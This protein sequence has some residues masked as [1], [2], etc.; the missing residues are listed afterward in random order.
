M[1][2]SF[3]LGHWILKLNGVIDESLMIEAINQA[4]EAEMFKQISFTGSESFLYPDLLIKGSSY[5]K[6][7]GFT[8]SVATNVFGVIG[9][10][11]KL[12]QYCLRQSW[13]PYFLVLIFF[14][15]NI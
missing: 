9:K 2:E 4:K 5:A 3:Y 13:M 11:I 14:I 7:L 6:K 1:L 15:M 12:T 10:R 8:T